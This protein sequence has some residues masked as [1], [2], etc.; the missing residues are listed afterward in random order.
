MVDSHGVDTVFVWFE[1]LFQSQLTALLGLAVCGALL[2]E[3]QSSHNTVKETH[4]YSRTLSVN[5]QDATSESNT[6][7]SDNYKCA[8]MILYTC[9]LVVFLQMTQHCAKYTKYDFVVH[10]YAFCYQQDLPS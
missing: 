2:L 1:H 8:T 5:L 10:V 3:G 9:A 7:V 6:I 4:K